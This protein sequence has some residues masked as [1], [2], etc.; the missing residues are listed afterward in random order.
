MMVK[1]KKTFSAEKSCLKQ[2]KAQ[3]IF[4]ILSSYLETKGLSWRN[5]VGIYTDSA[6]SV[7]DPM[8]GFT[9]LVKKRKF[10]CCQNTLLSA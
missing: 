3:D 8:R 2:P 5:C 7:V 9:S 4:N 10:S 6:P 1:F